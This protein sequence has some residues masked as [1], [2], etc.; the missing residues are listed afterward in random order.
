[1]AQ[2]I[3]ITPAGNLG[4]IPFGV[5]YKIPLEAYDPESSQ[6]IY[7]DV[8]AG[9]LPPGFECDTSSPQPNLQGVPFQ[10]THN[11]TSKFAIRAYTIEIVDGIPVITSLNDRTFSLTVTNQ[12]LPHFTTPAG[13]V[14]QYYDGTVVTSTLPDGTVIQGLQIDYTGIYDPTDV[15][16]TLVSGQLPLGTTISSTGLITGLILPNVPTD[17]EAGFSRDFEGYSDYPFDFSNTGQSMTYEFTL[18]VADGDFND[19][20][21]FYINVWAKG[22]LTADNTYITADNTFI[23]ADETNDQPPVLLTPPGSIGTTTNDS[24]YA[25][26]FQSYSVTGDPVKYEISVGP[27]IGFDGA[28]FASTSFDYSPSTLPPGLTLDENSGWL[29]GFI[30]DLGLT[31]ITYNFAVR[32]YDAY[33]AQIASAWSYYSLTIQGQINT[34]VLWLTDT[35][36]GTIDN[37]GVST[38][39]VKAI[40]T[41]N[42]QLYYQ[43]A[44]G[45]YNHLPQALTLLPDGEIVGRVTFNT[46]ALDGGYTT[47]DKGTTTFDMVCVFTVNAYSLDGYVSVYKEFYITVIRKYNEP[48]ENLYIQ[49][50][51]PLVQRD[52]ISQ[53]TGDTTIFLPDLIYRPNDPNFGVSNSVIYWHAYGLTSATLDEYY[54]SLYENHY[55]KDL[56]LGELKTAR[57]LD[58]DGNVLYEVVYSYVVDN[59]VNNSGVSVGKDVVLP[60]PIGVDD[61]LVVY[62][63]SLVDMRT[64]VIDVVGQVSNVLPRWMLSIQENGHV[65]GFTPA[66]V[67]AYTKPGQSAHILYNIQQSY[68]AS[69]LNSYDFKVDR[70]E[71][72]RTLSIHWNPV[73]HAWTPTPSETTFDVYDRP[74][75]LSYLGDVDYGTTQA[76]I[77]INRRTVN[78]INS[79]GG[80]DGPIH[81]NLNNKTIIFVQ[82]EDYNSPINS[83]TPGYLTPDE[84]WTDNSPF[85]PIVRTSPNYV[86]AE[87]GYDYWPYDTTGYGYEQAVIISGQPDP[88]DGLP[89]TFDAEPFDLGVVVPGEIDTQ[90]YAGTNNLRMAIWKMTVDENDIVTLEVVENTTTYDYVTVTNGLNFNNADLYVP[91]APAPG[92]ELISWVPLPIT[93]KGATTFDMNSLLF[94]DPVDMYNA[95]DDYDAYLVF[96]HRNILG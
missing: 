59:L 83:Y 66:W 62:P 77:N 73:T 87:V 53:F 78:Y 20:R 86:S 23:T 12:L 65:L 27:L 48:Y 42:K 60:Y 70:Y 8:I 57:A 85:D 67:I 50:M 32:V 18:K 71:L 5:F 7:Y 56:V 94:I 51:A 58:D 89:G 93:Q 22:S 9:D 31:D 14:G 16:V 4:T 79:I 75:T 13:L 41:S 21:T 33:D 91:A 43:L 28:P 39:Y 80:I 19:V 82:Q 95:T 1:M 92:L 81:Q 47:F 17:Q 11:T 84:A 76:F 2:P 68:Y 52:M 26:Q 44:S 29:Y 61:E 35:N 6:P 34:N 30:P 24:Y 88:L 40:T 25:F 55:W 63:N 10:V 54:S 90:L 72:D 3:W 15:K 36:L 69:L 64:Q 46:F 45:A 96:P 38:F 49:P 37:G 74:S